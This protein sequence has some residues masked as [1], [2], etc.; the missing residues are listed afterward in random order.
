MI[1]HSEWWGCDLKSSLPPQRISCWA[2]TRS[3]GLVPT[4]ERTSVSSGEQ[5]PSHHWRRGDVETTACFLC[6]LRTLERE[7]NQPMMGTEVS[8]MDGGP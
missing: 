3:G 5:P 8:L 4:P 7:V 2:N 6:R 1:P